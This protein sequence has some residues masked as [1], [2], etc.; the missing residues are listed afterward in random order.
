MKKWILHVSCIGVIGACTPMADKET[1]QALDNYTH[2]VDSIY[3]N[4]KIWKTS[5]DTDFVEYPID[6]NDPTV[7][8]LDT[9]VTMPDKKAKSLVVSDYWGKLIAEQYQPLKVAV[10]SK[11]EKMDDRMKK[12]YESARLKFEEMES[13][14]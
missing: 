1:Q 2:F 5:N 11:L 12:E 10:E 9:I 14:K 3:A 4:N 6:P 7:I 13:A 8:A